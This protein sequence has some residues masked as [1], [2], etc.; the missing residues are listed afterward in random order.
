MEG[1]GIH[2]QYQCFI[3]LICLDY[4]VLLCFF[5]SPSL[6]GLNPPSVCLSLSLSLCLLLSQ[7]SQGF[8]AQ[9]DKCLKNAEYLYDQLQRRTG[10]ELV[11]KNKVRMVL[12]GKRKGFLKCLKTSFINKDT[13]HVKYITVTSSAF[14][15]YNP[16]LILL[17]PGFILL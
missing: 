12:A 5:S 7:G 4:F 8:G 17:F 14:Y 2:A 16:L 11:Y 1:K 6:I 13:F 10:F 15:Y 3:K 9:V